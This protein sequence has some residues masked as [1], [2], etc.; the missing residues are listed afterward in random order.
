[1][2]TEIIENRKRDSTDSGSGQ[3]ASRE[4][5]MTS[6]YEFPHPRS[7]HLIQGQPRADPFV[8]NSLI[9]LFGLLFCDNYIIMLRN[10]IDDTCMVKWV[11]LVE[12][13]P[14][15][16]DTSLKKYKDNIQFESIWDSIAEAMKWPLQQKVLSRIT[17]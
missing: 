11:N 15:L 12:E 5:S 13:H 2:L 14:A 8:D 6:F 16:Y 17:Y 10:V 4:H 9:F 3:H 7:L 1:M